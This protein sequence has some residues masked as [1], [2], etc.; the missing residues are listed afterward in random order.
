[1]A[2]PLDD[3]PNELL[4]K[5]LT[6]VLAYSV[7]TVVISSADVAWYLRAHHTLSSVSF[8]FRE[9]MTG[10]SSK[11]F[12]FAVSDATPTLAQ[13]VHQQMLALR[14][15]GG[16][17]R[18]PS[19]PGSFSLDA[20]DARAPSLVQGY[21]LYVAIV[22]LRTQAAR[23]TPSIFLSTSSTIFGAVLALS[24][25]LYN[26]VVPGEVAALLHEATAAEAALSTISVRV[27]K[28]C[29][30]LADLVDDLA[31]KDEERT[32]L[33]QTKAEEVVGILDG[34]DAEF[35]TLFRRSLPCCTD[36]WVARLPDVY[37]TLERVHGVV[38][39]QEGLI[40]E[41]AVQKLGALVE[42]W[43]PPPPAE[44]GNGVAPGWAACTRC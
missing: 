36:R 14:A 15:L 1:M 28:H 2:L 23:S 22:Y 26:R 31:A 7:H 32:E 4:F 34:A 18:T 41:D 39:Q 8:V 25:V 35:R 43:A 37:S 33:N 40:G 42:A 30:V 10:I 17:I 19:N 29:G 13:H 11:A 16:A 3:L 6:H 5:I 12:D 44:I 21:S 24:G 9:L 27:V 20:L 38:V